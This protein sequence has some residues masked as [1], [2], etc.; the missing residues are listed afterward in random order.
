M[1]AAVLKDQYM[2]NVKFN[3]GRKSDCSKAMHNIGFV[4]L[5]IV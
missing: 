5:S 4:K 2:K 1:K 3:F